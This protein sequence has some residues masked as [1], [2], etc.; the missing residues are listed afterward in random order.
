MH[1][2]LF[3]EEFNLQTQFNPW[4]CSRGDVLR[5]WH[6]AAAPASLSSFLGIGIL[7]A[8]APLLSSWE[9]FP[10]AL[11][12]GHCCHLI[13]VPGPSTALLTHTAPVRSLPAPLVS[14]ALV[15]VQQPLQDT[16]SHALAP[17]PMV[18]PSGSAGVTPRFRVKLFLILLYSCSSSRVALQD[19]N[20]SIFCKGE[21]LITPVNKIWA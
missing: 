18:I 19:P 20:N 15:C 21:S 14:D 7:V 8:T 17:K 5:C 12:E 4:I 2:S 10:C 6:S 16:L 1:I 11:T 13:P 3:L 9:S